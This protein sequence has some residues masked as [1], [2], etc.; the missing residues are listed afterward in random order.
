MSKPYD[1][2]YVGAGP[3]TMFSVLTLLD[4]GYKGNICIIE[5]GESLKT[6]PKTEVISGVFGAGAFSDFKIT[7]ALEVG[8][9]IPNIEQEEL[10]K[11]SEYLIDNLNRFNTDDE[12]IE[13]GTT[14]S[15]D[16]SG[17][18]LN[19]SQHKTCHVGTDRGQHICYNIEKYISNSPNV[20]LITDVRVETINYTDGIYV[21]NGDLKTEHLVIATGQ[22]DEL[23]AL[24]VEEF[25]LKS[26]PRAFQLG[27]R[28]EDIIN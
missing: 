6:R 18:D 11:F 20:D 3:S 21:L 26:T 2:T 22:K 12:K 28:V 14:G 16:T 8:G 5:K 17:T 4:Y 1:I 7:S 10:D 24:C 27:I 15:F 13:W 23:P 19:F 25:N 9:T